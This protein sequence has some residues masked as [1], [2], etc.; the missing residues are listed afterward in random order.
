MMQDGDRGTGSLNFSTE[1]N[2][3]IG[4]LPN[5]GYCPGR[6]LKKKKIVI[7]YQGRKTMSFLTLALGL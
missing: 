7:P 4:G 6:V 3:K 2:D 5:P 1:N